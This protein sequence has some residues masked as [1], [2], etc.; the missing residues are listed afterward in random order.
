MEDTGADL[1]DRLTQEVTQLSTRLVTAVA[2]SS[3][4]EERILHLHKENY[5]L[6]NK[7]K[8]LTETSQKYNELVPKY[9][10]LQKEHKETVRAKEEAESQN[11]K[12]QGEVED[13]TASLFNEANEMVS[14]ASRE[15]YN[16][17]VK[18]RKLYEEIDEKNTIIESL[19]D[20]LKD[21]KSLFVKME[22]QLKDQTRNKHKSIAEEEPGQ[23]SAVENEDESLKYAQQLK[24]IV[25]SPFISAIRFDLGVYQHEFKV[26]IYNLIKPEFHFDFTNL[27][28]FKFF[29][30]VWTEELEGSLPNIPNIATS[31][32]M[33]RW[34]KGKFFWSL[35]VE[36]KVIIAPISG[37]NEMFKLTYKGG[38][39]SDE[40]PVAMKDPCSFCGESR[41]D[42]LEHARLYTVKLLNPDS[43]TAASD[44]NDVLVSYPCCNFCLIKLRNVCD[45]FAKLRSIHTNV[46]KLK[47]NSKYDESTAHNFQFRRSFNSPSELD[48]VKPDSDPGSD[49]RETPED[50]NEEYKLMK[51]YILLQSCRNKIFWSKIGYWD[52]TTDTDS[53][54]ISEI[55]LDAFKELYNP[56]VMGSTVS[57]AAAA[58][59]TAAEDDATA[60]ANDPAAA[61]PN[62]ESQVPDSQDH[63]LANSDASDDA[64]HFLDSSDNFTHPPTPPVPSNPVEEP[65]SPIE[66]PSPA[67]ENGLTRK[68]SKSK[69]FKKKVDRD[70]N[71][72]LEM[73]Q[74]S[75]N[76]S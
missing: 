48:G 54:D 41:N 1:D 6:R 34:S 28:N 62:P 29:R 21:L 57:A 42:V 49:I 14:N 4:L 27:K 40:T 18:N 30:K 22:D 59:A 25:F 70:L 35:I 23:S 53:S 52:N 3:E 65:A 2:K 24:Q 38:R 8:T 47:P 73:L 50:K 26:F 39:S 9:N 68:S 11:K 72:T 43:S 58:G 66:E 19:Q 71:D 33:N 36:G 74:E 69:Q 56:C 46:Y 51:L 13:L 63:E 15:T 37:V 76:D 75:I 16:F 67:I 55:A 20:Q 64:G 7:V 17:K 12:L 5:Q 45:F 60:T 10:D 31:N 32:F 61:T 44:S